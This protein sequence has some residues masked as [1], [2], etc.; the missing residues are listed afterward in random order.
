MKQAR[1]LTNNEFKRILAV[2]AAHKHAARN[3]AVFFL[4]FYAGMRACEIASLRVRDVVDDDFCVKPQIVLE[5]HMT[6][7]NE[8]QRV[9]LN[10]KLQKE[11]QIFVDSNCLTRLFAAPLIQSQKGGSF[12]P[13]TLVQLFA[14]F[15]EKAGISG[16]SSHSGRRQFI[17][18]LAEKQINVRV[19]QALARHRHLNTTMRYID[20]N[21]VKLQ[22][23]VEF[24]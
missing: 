23:A 20:V 17:T 12:S 14:R 18:T 21:D 6:K 9:I 1:I 3:R 5:K 13:L 11:L 2:I 22:T 15:Y 16:A 4:S 7:G 24:V 10:K 8:R 19:I